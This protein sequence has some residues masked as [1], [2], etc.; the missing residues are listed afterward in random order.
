MGFKEKAPRKIVDEPKDFVRF[1]YATGRHCGLMALGSPRI[2]QR[3]PLGK[4]GLIP[5]E[6]ERLAL[7]GAPQHGGPRLLAPL[8]ALGL[9]EM[10]GDKAGFLVGK[11]QVVQQSTAIVGMILYPKLPLDEVLQHRGTPAPRGIACRLWTRL[12]QGGEGLPLRFGQ[13]CRSSWWTLI[14]QTG[15]P[16]SEET[17]K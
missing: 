5:K 1:A 13:L 12:D 2:A 8:Q 4:D 11:A 3:A 15:N 14:D 10:I 16:M 7:A 17:V 9:I 6:Q